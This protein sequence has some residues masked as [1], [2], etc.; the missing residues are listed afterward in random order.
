VVRVKVVVVVKAQVSLVA[1]VNVPITNRTQRL[2]GTEA[3]A[4]PNK[5][6]AYPRVCLLVCLGWERAAGPVTRA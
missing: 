2:Y 6:S 5:P 4:V 1:E 3:V